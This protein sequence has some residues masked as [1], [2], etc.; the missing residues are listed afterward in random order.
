MLP[1]ARG[2]W[3]E[4][5]VKLGLGERG[6]I[7]QGMECRLDPLPQRPSGSPRDSFPS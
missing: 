2:G 3:L 1:L 5:D 7:E 6:E 4:T